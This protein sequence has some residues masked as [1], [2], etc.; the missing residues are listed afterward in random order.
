[1]KSASRH[2]VSERARSLA[3]AMRREPTEAEIALWRVL[4]DRRV[5]AMKW[6]R[7][8]PLGAFIVDF[9]CLEH[10]LVVECDGSQHAEN[11]RDDARDAWLLSQGFQ[12]ARLWN[13]EVL[14]ERA[15]VVDTILARCGLPW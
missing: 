14:R 6:R 2:Q 4:R 7:Q 1:M 10:R 8:F 13:H 11:T 12:V 5:S 3:R 9:V 15:S